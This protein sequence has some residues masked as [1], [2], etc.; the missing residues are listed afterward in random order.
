MEIACNLLDEG[1]SSVSDVMRRVVE[2]AAQAGVQQVRGE[3]L[4]SEP[5]SGPYVLGRTRAQLLA[6]AARDFQH[7]I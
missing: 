2:L 5:G 3:E 7:I 4:G 1:Q 6:L